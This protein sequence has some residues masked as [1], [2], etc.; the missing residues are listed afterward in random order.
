MFNRKRNSD[1]E[2]YLDYDNN[3]EEEELEFD[4][5]REYQINPDVTYE[6]NQWPSEEDYS[7]YQEQQDD[8]NPEYETRSQRYANDE[9]EIPYE[10]NY[11]SE[12]PEEYTEE[13]DE[14]E[15]TRTSQNNAIPRRAKY[16]ARIDRFL[17]NG[18]II[19]G[20]LLIIV[21]VIAFLL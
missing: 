3:P 5:T 14:Q 19:V 9:Q 2:D 8:F 18:I 17:N 12:I 7:Y 1:Y 10:S 11:E 20:V 6:E 4:E 21:L 13:N 15:A 16:N